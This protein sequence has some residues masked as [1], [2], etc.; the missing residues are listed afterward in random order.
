MANNSLKSKSVH[1]HSESD[2]KKHWDGI[3]MPYCPGEGKWPMEQT[4]ACESH[5]CLFTV[6][7]FLSNCGLVREKAAIEILSKAQVLFLP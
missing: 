1:L 4:R 3:D 6:G 5:G 7:G 2:Y